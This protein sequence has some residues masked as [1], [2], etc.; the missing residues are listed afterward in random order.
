MTRSKQLPYLASMS[1][2]IQGLVYIWIHSRELFPASSRSKSK[3]KMQKK[4][5]AK[6]GI[7]RSVGFADQFVRLSRENCSKTKLKGENALT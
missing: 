7:F 5:K 1:R 4:K 6:N 3:Y 2:G